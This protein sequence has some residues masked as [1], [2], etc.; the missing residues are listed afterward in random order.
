MAEHRRD[1]VGAPHPGRAGDAAAAR[2]AR[3]AAARGD[4]HG[5]ARHAP[6]CASRTSTSARSPS[7]R[8]RQETQKALAR[9]DAVSAQRARADPRDARAR[10]SCASS[11]TPRRTGRGAS[12]R[13]STRCGARRGRTARTSVTGILLVD[14]PE[15]L[16]SAGV[17]RA[18]KARAR[19]AKVGHL[20]TL[21]PV[22]ERA[23]AAL[24]RRGDE[25]R[26]LPAAR[27]QG[28]HGHDPPGRRDRHARPHRHA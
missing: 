7:R 25:G 3:P 27:A 22:R 2:G 18:L 20:G 16:T 8:R 26:A 13:C 1:R 10:R 15:G 11:T 21:D 14:K 24:P 4:H 12:T 17:I 5:R 6:I 28:V 19:A 23:A 9:R